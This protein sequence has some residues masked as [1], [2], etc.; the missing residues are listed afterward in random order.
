VPVEIVIPLLA[1]VVVALLLAIVIRRAGRFLTA[2]READAFRNAVNDLGDRIATSLGGV[3][4][5]I[6]AVRRHQVSAESIEENL[7]AGRDAVGRYAQEVRDLRAPIDVAAQRE[8]LIAE[9]ERAGRALDMVVHGCHLMASQP[10]PARELEAQTSIKRGYLNL[11]HAR[12]AIARLAADV[13]AAPMP[14]GKS[15]LGRRVASDR[16]SQTSPRDHTM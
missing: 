1:F 11:I 6:D 2:T 4:E 8:G 12:E 3:I 16:T 14:G 10:G 15:F 7:E 13:A 9:L 5:R